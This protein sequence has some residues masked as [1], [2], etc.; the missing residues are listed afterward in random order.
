M[1]LSEHMFYYILCIA[2]RQI[3]GVKQKRS[4]QIL[5]PFQETN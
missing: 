2:I 3:L 5:Y 1:A 4:Q